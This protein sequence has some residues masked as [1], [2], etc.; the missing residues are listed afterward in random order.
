M[1]TPRIFSS[2]GF[3]AHFAAFCDP[4][5]ALAACSVRSA[6]KVTACSRSLG[7]GAYRFISAQPALCEK[8]PCA[9]VVG[10]LPAAVT[11]SERTHSPTSSPAL[12]HTSAHV[13]ASPETHTSRHRRRASSAMTRERDSGGCAGRRFPMFAARPGVSVLFAAAS[14]HDRSERRSHTITWCLIPADLSAPGSERRGVVW[15]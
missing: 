2:R 11:I 15:R 7:D 8:S 4:R 1:S 13:V 5:A 6:A 12:K 3:H 10:A 9:A 14:F